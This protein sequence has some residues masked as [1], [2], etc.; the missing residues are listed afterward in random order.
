[1]KGVGISQ[2][3]LYERVEKSIIS[4]CK[5]PNRAKRCTFSCEKVNKTFWFVSYTYFKESTFTAV[6]KDANV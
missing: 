6:K 5:R 4:V 1:M 2:A 3:E